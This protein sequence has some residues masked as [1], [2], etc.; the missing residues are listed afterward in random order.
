ML[1][2][3]GISCYNIIPVCLFVTSVLEKDFNTLA[4]VL[5]IYIIYDVI[6]TDLMLFE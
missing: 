2:F 1:L 6:T 3:W 4:A 5:N